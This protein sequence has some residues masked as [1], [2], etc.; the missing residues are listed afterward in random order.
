MSEPIDDDEGK[1]RFLVTMTKEDIAALDKARRLAGVSR[2]RFIVLAIWKS[3][4]DT[5]TACAIC[6]RTDEHVH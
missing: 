5:P 1:V 6:G 2:N 3:I 4:K